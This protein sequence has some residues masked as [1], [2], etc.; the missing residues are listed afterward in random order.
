[1]RSFDKRRQMIVPARAP[2][3]RLLLL[4][5]TT[6][7]LWR[8]ASLVQHTAHFRPSSSSRT[9]WSAILCQAQVR[10]HVHVWAVLC[11]ALASCMSWSLPLLSAPT[12]RL[13]FTLQ[14]QPLDL[15]AARITHITYSYATRTQLGPGDRIN[16]GGFGRISSPPFACGTGD[17]ACMLRADHPRIYSHTASSYDGRLF[18]PSHYTV[19]GQTLRRNAR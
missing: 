17:F 7:I 19:L 6:P 4:Y 2:R 16:D 5:Y 18:H 12:H 10:A 13:P 11:L 1:M 3:R 8:Q 15:T 9:G 14:H